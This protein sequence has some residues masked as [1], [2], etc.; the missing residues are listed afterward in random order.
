MFDRSLTPHYGVEARLS[1][2]VGRVLAPN[3]GPYTFRGTGVYIIGAG[4]AV[5]VID[6]GPDMPEHIKALQRALDGR[7][8][9]HILI[10]HTHRDHSPA[11]AALKTLTGAKTFGYGPHPRNGGDVEAG[12]DRTFV[13][14]ML[15][16]D[17]DILSGDG[18]TLECVHTPGHISNHMCFALKE[19]DALFTGDHVM[20][21]STSVVAPPDGNMADY[22]R[23]LDRLIVRGDSILYPTHG[24]PIAHPGPFLRATMAHRR[25]RAAQ[26]RDCIARGDDTVAA[27][28]DRL[29]P[30]IA[31][32][33]RLA[34]SAMVLAHLEQ[35]RQEGAVAES[36]ERWI[37]QSAS[38]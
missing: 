37:L 34:A 29:Y 15:I 8:V 30:D 31:P 22:L 38:G 17:G 12:G 16:R 11:A 14:D 19:E 35:M 4:N 28:V 6:P 33:L 32:E 1:R 9:T 36:E 26:I 3:P 5:A 20:G 18:F 25:M 13:P 7:T 2:L 24:S 21:W 27:M 23:S 10:T